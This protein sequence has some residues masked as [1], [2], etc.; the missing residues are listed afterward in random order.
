M[1]M[2]DSFADH[3]EESMQS[4]DKIT[5]V[6]KLEV[7]WDVSNCSERAIMCH[8]QDKPHQVAELSQNALSCSSQRG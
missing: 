7:G 6:S 5:R 8:I 3:F 2:A 4:P 1:P